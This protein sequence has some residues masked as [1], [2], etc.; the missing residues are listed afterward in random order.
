MQAIGS[1]RLLL[2][3]L[4]LA[5]AALGGTFAASAQ[6]IVVG[7]IGPW[8]VIPVPDAPQVNAGL[9]AHF[10]QVNA[11]GG[12]NGRR[13]SLFEL[14][15]AYAADTFVQRFEEAMKRKPVA[16][17]SPIGSA[18]VKRMLDDKLL[19]RHDVVVL[20][21]I[22]GAESLR[23]PGHPRFFHIRAGDRQQ[24]EKMVQHARTLGIT[25]M[26]ALY[27]TIEM[28]ESAV[29]VA[30]AEVEKAGGAALRSVAAPREAGAIAAA[31][32]QIA[33]TDTQ[34]V[35]VL[36][37][38]R[39]TVDAI[40]ELRKAGASPSMFAFSY[41][42]PGLLAKVAGADA[43]RGVGIAQ[44]FPNPAGVNT[45]L[46]RE[47]QA[48]MKAAFPEV[49]SYTS[50]HLEGY[51]TARVL[52]EALRRAPQATPEALART[53]RGMGEVDLGG[54]RVRFEKNNVGSSFVDI[55]VMTTGGRLMY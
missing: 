38:P 43:A 14:D 35:L 1:W 48:A 41:V 21:A 33:A 51:I 52:T 32:R 17:L 34:N 27:E 54:Y 50:F 3:R 49:T 20:N 44:T 18:A 36:G 39:F 11:R 24:V 9:K 30:K 22:P 53:L 42:P 19:D 45:P 16:L 7:Q 25:R 15:D 55:G 23:A 2:G 37:S 31:A 46:Q 13:I 10:A 12:I 40:A 47:F 28:G 8:T 26:T 29:A 6:D 5:A 4:A